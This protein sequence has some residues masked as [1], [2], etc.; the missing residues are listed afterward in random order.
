MLCDQCGENESI[1]HLTRIKDN[2]IVTSH[3]CE[4]CAL[5]QGIEPG[6]AMSDAPLTDFLAQTGKALAESSA[7]VGPC[8]FCGMRLENFKKTGRLGCSH[9]YVTFEPHL[10]N[11]LKRLHGKEQHVGK[12]Y[13]P[14]DPSEAERRERL[15]GLRRKLDRAVEAEDFE[16]AARIRDQIRT[17]ETA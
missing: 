11:L 7:T 12:V 13:L 5:A 2:K 14:S 4:S 1:V 10:R 17:L 6:V 3:L 16:Q 15:A 9:C 8:A